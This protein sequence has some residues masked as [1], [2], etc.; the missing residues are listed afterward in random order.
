MIKLSLRNGCY[1]SLDGSID[2]ETLLQKRQDL[3]LLSCDEPLYRTGGNLE[4]EA[5]SYL[6]SLLPLGYVARW[7]HLEEG[8]CTSKETVRTLP[9]MI[10]ELRFRVFLQRAK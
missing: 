1:S 6:S 7:D 5:A 10:N 4:Q 2:L 9:S 8:Y 3:V